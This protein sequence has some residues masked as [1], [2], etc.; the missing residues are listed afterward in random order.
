MLT[1]GRQKIGPNGSE[2]ELFV[3]RFYQTWIKKVF[4]TVHTS[5][6]HDTNT[7]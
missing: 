7:Y 4:F 5:M 2:F 1:Q 3:V 6:F